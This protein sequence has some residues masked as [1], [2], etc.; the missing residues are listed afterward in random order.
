M[1]YMCNNCVAE[2]YSIVPAFILKYW[3]FKKFSI[4]KK[5]KEVITK[6]FEKPI[7]LIKSYDRLLKKSML[8]EEA[9]VLKRKIHKIFDLMKCEKAEQVALSID[10]KSTRLNSSH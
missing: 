4:S 7:I 8:L 10:R 5:A 3:N 6:W 2:E 9:V 1:R